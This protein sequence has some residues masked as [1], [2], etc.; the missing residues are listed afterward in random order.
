MSSNKIIKTYLEPSRK[1]PVLGEYDVVVC[2]GG[3]AGCA[4][5]ASA[6]RLGAKT[7]LVE[8]EGHL[9]GAAVNQLVCV[10]LSTNGVDFQGIWHEWADGLRKR[11]GIGKFWKSPHQMSSVV[12]P[13][14]VKYVW[15]D[16]LTGAKVQILHHAYTAGTIA[17]KNVIKGI[18]A[19]TRAGRRAIFAKRV[20]DCTGDGIVCNAA[21]VPWE[22]GD[23]INKWAMALTKVFRIANASRPSKWP[24]EKAMMKIEKELTAAIKRGEFKASVVVEKKRLL[25]YIRGWAWKLPEPRNEIMS[26]IS[27]I[28]KVDPLDPWDITR[29]EREGR[30]QA[31][32]AAEV[33]RRFVPGFEESYLLDTSNQVGVRSSRRICGLSTVTERD[34]K[35]FITYPDEIAK[36]SWDIDVWPANSYSAPA[37]PR[38]SDEW[39]KRAERMSK[40]AYFSIRYGC[41]VAKGI[42]NLLMAGR[43][44]SAEH[45]A[46]SSLRIQ[47]TCM[48]TGQAAGTAATLSIA[49]KTTPRQLD[50]MLVVNKLEKDR[51]KINEKGI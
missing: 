16:L 29:A 15:D 46:E 34:A 36:S 47:Q 49:K 20:I 39:K 35:E 19:E 27:R 8:K 10:V 51:K 31:W 21:G 25:N 3:P 30:A 17:G 14:T 9:G 1:I 22:Q 37:V 18:I 24:D 43:C 40:G 44:I 33:Y 28:L 38:D 48:S 50:P 23:G 4:A 42:D 13:E 2:G 5:A 45:V 11:N 12:N 6:A 7:L 32:E 41:I 26:V